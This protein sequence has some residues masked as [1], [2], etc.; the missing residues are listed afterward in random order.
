[1][2]ILVALALLYVLV[3]A[4]P[5][6]AADGETRRALAELKALCDRGLVDAAVCREKQRAILGLPATVPSP[7]AQRA[8]K[9]ATTIEPQ[10][11]QSPLGFRITLPPGWLPVEPDAVRS[12]FAT[13]RQ[14]VDHGGPTTAL[15]DR[16]ERQALDGTIDFFA[17]G[18]DHVQVQR[19]PAPP[20]ADSAAL[21]RFCARLE[22]NAS[23]TAGRPLSTQA[24]GTRLV[25]GAPA[26]YV[27]RDALLPGMRTV[28]YWV[29]APHRRA[30]VFVLSCAQDQPESCRRDFDAM[31]GSL[32]WPSAL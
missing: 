12:G 6:R 13:L 24:C 3:G 31:V 8:E 14:Q 18:R 4:V 15:L 11:H 26:L 1:V 28:Q 5:A 30:V 17:H 9:P 22:A 19:A 25:A 23:R 21:A 10:R 20:P 32:V 7:A 29:P 27:E 2:P 16:L